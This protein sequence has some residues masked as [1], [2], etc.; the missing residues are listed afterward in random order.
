MCTVAKGWFLIFIIPSK[1]PEIPSKS[2]D[3]EIFVYEKKMILYQG[4][5]IK[6]FTLEVVILMTISAYLLNFIKIFD[7]AVINFH[8]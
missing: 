3:K 5:I 2:I 4:K 6:E 8:S 7:E 1:G